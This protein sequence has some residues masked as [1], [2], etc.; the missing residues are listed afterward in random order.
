[1][2]KYLLNKF[3]DTE[4]KKKEEKSDYFI[5]LGYNTTPIIP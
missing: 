5:G 3:C 2:T 4:R 1:M